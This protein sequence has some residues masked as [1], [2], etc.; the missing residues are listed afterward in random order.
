MSSYEDI[1]DDARHQEL[2]EIY[3]NEKIDMVVYIRP[4]AIPVHIHAHPDDSND[5]LLEQAIDS[6]LD[7]TSGLYDTSNI[8]IDQSEFIEWEVD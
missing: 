5:D 7:K 2:D 1:C 3:E 4:P 6:L 8:E